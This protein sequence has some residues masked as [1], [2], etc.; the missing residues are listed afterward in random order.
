MQGANLRHPETAIAR[1]IFS[2]EYLSA[3]EIAARLER[4]PHEITEL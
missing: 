3:Y 2:P 1:A 4:L